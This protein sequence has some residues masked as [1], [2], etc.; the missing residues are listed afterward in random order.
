MSSSGRAW[1]DRRLGEVHQAIEVGRHAERFPLRVFFR[2]RRGV[3]TG[4]EDG[5]GAE[6]EAE[7]RLLLRGD[8]SA[9]AG[10]VAMR[11]HG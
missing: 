10:D 11:V 2:T 9:I 6:E 7:S 5:V 4:E 3:D 8:R 1:S